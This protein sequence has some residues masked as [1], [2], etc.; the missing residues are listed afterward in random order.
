MNI[1]SERR[2]DDLIIR[3][4][5]MLTT[6][7]EDEHI[8]PNMDVIIDS[9]GT[10]KTKCMELAPVYLEEKTNKLNKSDRS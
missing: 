3:L 6:E 7:L 1:P 5:E 8:V 10:F 2:I 9:I 4:A